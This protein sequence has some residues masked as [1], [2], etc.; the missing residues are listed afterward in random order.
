MKSKK[1]EIKINRTFPYLMIHDSSSAI[2][3]ATEMDED[4]I[5][6]TI[7]QTTNPERF[8]LGQYCPSWLLKY[9]KELPANVKVTLSNE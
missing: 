6:G 2:I 7:V 9:W 1:E 3:L 5:S 8:P 4:T